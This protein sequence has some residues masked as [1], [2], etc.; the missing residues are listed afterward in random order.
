MA[1]RQDNERRFGEW[2][3]LPEGGRRYWYVRAGHGGAWVR[4]LKVVD[5]DEVTLSFA[6]EVYDAA[7]RLRAVHG[8]YPADTGHH[9][10]PSEVC[11]R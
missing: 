11:E 1:R 6:Q 10:L 7:G 4:Y 9:R 5:A 3:E 2:E 8:K